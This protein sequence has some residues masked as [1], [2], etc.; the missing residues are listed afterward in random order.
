MTTYTGGNTANDMTQWNLAAIKDGSVTS[1]SATEVKITGSDNLFYDFMGHDLHLSASNRFDGGTITGLQLSDAAARTYYTI[2]D[3]SVDAST[4]QGYINTNN[5]AAFEN[6]V[7]G[8]NDAI[9]GSGQN[10]VLAGFAGNDIVNGRAGIDTA[11]YADATS[12]VHVSLAISGQQS[13]GG[14]DGKDTLVSIENLTGSNFDD[15][16]TGNSGKNVL[17]GRGGNDK[18][19]LT[20]GG[21]DQA[22]G[23]E[24]N[25]TFIFGAAFNSGDAADG[26]NG[27][28]V[29]R[30]DGDY[31]AGVSLAHVRDIEDL[32]LG[33]GHS[34]VLNLNQTAPITVV[35]S[36]LGA[37]NSLTLDGHSEAHSVSVYDGAGNDVITTG[38]GDDT[39]QA[40]GGGSDTVSTH[41]GNDLIIFGRTLDAT[42]HID[43]GGGIDT[44]QLKKTMIGG[45]ALVIGPANTNI[46][47]IETYVLQSGHDYDVRASG[48]LSNVLTTVDGSQLSASDTLNFDASD[49]TN[50]RL[51]A[52]G[53]GS[54]DTLTGSGSADSLIGGGGN[55]VLAGN[56]EE[57][58]LEGDGG[59]DTLT[60]GDSADTFRYLHVSDST[61]THFD[62][63]TDFTHGQDK[64]QIIPKSM[65]TEPTVNGGTLTMEN[66]DSDL[67]AA[68]G[69][70]HGLVLFKPSSGDTGH[71][72]F[73][74][75]NAGGGAGYQADFDFVIALD[76]VNNISLADIVA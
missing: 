18:F 40:T 64:I 71:D 67:A 24:G 59:R 70:L 31:S 61:S 5:V 2:G 20:A 9:T 53:G 10:D 48:D 74:V 62:I 47:S 23:G 26:G 29:L 72:T 54:N 43:G 3:F 75:V 65:S 58:I 8:G 39:L 15:T 34:Y 52:L 57:D 12:G 56:Q 55:D 32:I 44:L 76:G 30:L 13:V 41:G 69:D 22:F 66:F 1:S 6:A 25:D 7:F 16:L 68:V 51:F 37:G 63:I 33:G 73:L 11:S 17:T 28:D 46:V 35:G 60:G 4:L 45:N 21:T 49:A 19:D 27:N 36:N 38:S 50:V 14:G 42:D